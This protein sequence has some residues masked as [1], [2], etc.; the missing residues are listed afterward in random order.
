L[1]GADWE[2]KAERGDGYLK[3]YEDKRI[4]PEMPVIEIRPD[5]REVQLN[6]F[7]RCY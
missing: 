3:V 5:K 7:T 1:E 2:Q 6:E 4:H